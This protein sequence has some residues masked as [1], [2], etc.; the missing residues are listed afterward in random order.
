MIFF[1]NAAVCLGLKVDLIAKDRV[2]ISIGI[3]SHG[4]RILNSEC[5]FQM[6]I[7]ELN[8]LYEVDVEEFFF[9]SKCNFQ[10]FKSY[11][12][13]LP[14]TS[15]WIDFE[16]SDKMIERK[17]QYMI[18]GESTQWTYNIELKNHSE[19][20]TCILTQSCLSYIDECFQF[21]EMLEKHSKI[22]KRN[23]KSLDF[24]HPFGPP[25]MTRPG[26]LMNCF[27]AYANKLELFAIPYEQTGR[28][29]P[30]CLKMK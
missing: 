8:N 6:T 10:K 24:F 27:L 12:G 1:L 19:R 20:N 4:A 15:Y 7:N 30:T 21:Q 29:K 28:K 26:F 3:T 23:E 11:T 13:Q 9:P 14:E 25:I 16:D 17:R 22:P 2:L 5:Y 18:K